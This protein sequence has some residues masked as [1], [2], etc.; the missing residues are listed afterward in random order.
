MVRKIKTVNTHNRIKFEPY[1]VL[2]GG[3]I[4]NFKMLHA[5]T[6]LPNLS[7]SLRVSI[8]FTLNI[9]IID[10]QMHF[11]WSKWLD[12]L[13]GHFTLFWK[14]DGLLILSCIPISGLLWCTETCTRLILVGVTRPYII[15]FIN[16]IQCK[17]SKQNYT[18]GLSQHNLLRESCYSFTSQR[19]L[20]E[21]SGACFSYNH[22][23]WSCA[24][25]KHGK[26][27]N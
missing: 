11:K 13:L 25:W 23:E 19:Y 22:S 20:T 3:A 2:T 1:P 5:W 12:L 27:F 10:W 15:R 8:T 14:R 24:L 9:L 18:T 26:R 17:I 16:S 21:N 7:S 4:I 6:L